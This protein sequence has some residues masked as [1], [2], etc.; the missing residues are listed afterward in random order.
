MKKNEYLFIFLV[1]LNILDVFTTVGNSISGKGGY[2]LNPIARYF[3]NYGYM[4][5]FLAKAIV[6][7]PFS[8][9]FYKKRKLLNNHKVFYALFFVN[10]VYTIIVVN[11][12]LGLI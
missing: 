8:I 9:F 4:G 7:I 5:L 2:E 3:L 6:F 1:I 11:N 10:Y 12:F